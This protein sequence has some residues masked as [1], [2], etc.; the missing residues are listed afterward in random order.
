MN[1]HEPG[2]TRE[3]D[4]V[5]V[6][7]IDYLE[8]YV[9]NARHAMHFYRTAFGFTPIAYAGPETGARDR[10]SLVGQQGRIRLVLTSA[11]NSEGP[12]AEHFNRHGEGVK[13]IA[14]AVADAA[15]AFEQ[16]VSSGARPVMEPTVF[17]DRDGQ[18]I[19]AT[20]ATFGDTV[21]SFI[22]RDGYR[23]VF[24]PYFSELK[25]HA[26]VSTGMELIDHLAVAVEPGVASHWV[27][28]YQKTLGLN[29]S[30][31]EDISSDYSGMSTKV[32]RNGLE[33]LVFVIVEPKPGA[34]QSPIDEYLMYYGGAGVHH[35]GV[36]STDIV[37][38]VG[39][40]RANG[41]EFAETPDA[42][43]DALEERIGQISEST[44]ELRARKILVDR[45]AWGYLMQIFA[46]PTQ[47]RPTFF[48]E[49]IQRAH[50]RGFGNG[51]IKALFEAI[52]REQ[53][54][55]GNTYSHQAQ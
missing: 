52:E 22:Q 23:G 54:L 27:E 33:T 32:V 13:D 43:Y 28:F 19:K 53:L 26:A 55:R 17:E 7:G 15:A 16:S 38:S 41:V 30:Q 4:A 47:T 2:G 1:R 5:R 42:Y 24:F 3:R 37:Q 11:M 6:L 12:I 10:I 8:L 34:R 9:G 46:K 49:I 51:N 25:N 48:F 31:E 35:I 39:A 18:V 45:D 40:L 50:A 20:V 14:L 21:H 36:Q 44:A 29:L